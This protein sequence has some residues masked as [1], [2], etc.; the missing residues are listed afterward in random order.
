M[1]YF[2]NEIFAC[3]GYLD[4]EMI[5]HSTQ[6]KVDPDNP[7]YLAARKYTRDAVIRVIVARCLNSADA[8]RFPIKTDDSPVKIFQILK[9]I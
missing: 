4:R 8:S 3:Q 6:A 7:H 9:V 5:Y 2:R 1:K